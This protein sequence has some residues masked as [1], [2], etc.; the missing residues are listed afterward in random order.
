MARNIIGLSALMVASMAFAQDGDAL[1]IG[2]ETDDYRSVSVYDTWEASPFR[3]GVLSGNAAVIDNNIASEYNGTDN[4]LAVQRSRFGSNTFGVRI[5]LKET[6]ELTPTPKYV[7]VLINKPVE[8]RVMLVGLGKR[9]DR[10]QQSSDVEQFW[11]MSVN[12]ITPGEWNDAVFSVTGNGG[13]DIY[14]LV[15]VPHCESPHSLEEDFIAYVDEIEVNGSSVPRVGA[16][17]YLI[18]FD[19]DQAYTRDDR[20]LNGIT[21]SGGTDGSQSIAIP[22]PRKMYSKI[23]STPLMARPGET[24]TASFDIKG[25]WTHGYVY[26]DR[27]NDGAFSYD[28]DGNVPAANSD[29]FAFSCYESYNSSGSYVSNKNVV[30]PPSFTIPADLRPG[31][32]RMRFKTDWNCVDP[33]GNLDPGNVML[34]N[35]GG[36]LD[37]LVNIHGDYAYVSQANRNGEVLS[38]DGQKLEN[39]RVP[40]GQDFKIK[41]NPE[42]GFTYSGIRVRHGYNLAGD[43]LVHGNPQ[44]QDVI[45]TFDEFD[46]DDTFTIP[47]RYIDGD[48]NIEGMFVESGTLPASVTVTYNLIHE[49]DVLATKSHRVNEGEPY[50]AHGFEFECSSEYFTVSGIPEGVVGAEDETIDVQLVHTAP[51]DVSRDI[52]HAKWY[53]VTITSEPKYLHDNAGSGYITLTRSTTSMEY[54]DPQDLWCFIGNAFSGFKLYNKQAGIGKILSSNVDTSSNTG[55]N[56]YPVMTSEPVPSTHNTYW[57]PVAS[58][59]TIDGRKGFFLHQQG[60]PSNCMN[61]RDGRLAYWT[62]GVDAGSTFVC[63]LALD[64]TSGID[65]IYNDPDGTPIYYNLQGIRISSDSLV[66]GIY[67][68]H[69]GNKKDKVYID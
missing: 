20:C 37:V 53:Y 3:T 4:I 25:E 11:S 45:F 10:P 31:I 29:L 65:D 48:V 13:I 41:M 16:D 5:D 30:N 44:Y 43:S 12:T 61:S 66:P 69:Q 15:V 27:G 19:W 67:I 49:G 60:F 6:F 18:N 26:L 32:Y 62:G 7:H 39:F 59:Y 28:L 68:R 56:T 23:F 1:K 34:A 14:S 54:P 51:F 57:I 22:A 52:N 42:N 21:L 40:F 47:G 63:T 33:A 8:G 38:A 2:F 64:E 35:G 50:P 36:F 24:V 58:S 46:A 17:D 9:K 55:G